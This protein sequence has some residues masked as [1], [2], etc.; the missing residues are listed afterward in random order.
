MI[1]PGIRKWIKGR[2]LVPTASVAEAEFHRE[3]LFAV[4]EGGPAA[5]FLDD[6]AQAATECQV[7]RANGCHSNHK[8]QHIYLNPAF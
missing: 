3:L 2:T 5:V 1:L 6:S 7:C 4:F 8:M